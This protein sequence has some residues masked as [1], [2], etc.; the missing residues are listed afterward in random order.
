[1][2]DAAI[3]TGGAEGAYW[4]SFSRD[5]I[6]TVYKNT[7]WAPTV[8]RQQLSWHAS[9]DTNNACTHTSPSAVVNRPINYSP[10]LTTLGAQLN[11]FLSSLYL[12]THGAKRIRSA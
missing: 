6:L 2:T 10:A 12:Y 8:A 7:W 3:K 9:S 4:E 1:M 11:R 5:I